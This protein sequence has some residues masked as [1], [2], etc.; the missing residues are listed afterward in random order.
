MAAVLNP[1]KS[2]KE[3]LIIMKNKDNIKIVLCRTWSPG[4][5]GSVLRAMKNF[6]FTNVVAVNQINENNDEI[7]TMA[8]GAKDHIKYLKKSSNLKEAIKD[9]NIVYAFTNRQRKFFKT[10]SPSQ[11]ASEIN[12]LAP[13]QKVALL[14][15]N[16]TNGLNSKEVDFADKIVVIPTSENY[17]S[18][19]LATAVMISLYEIH[20]SLL[21]DNKTKVAKKIV[22]LEEK[23]SLFEVISDV[24]C[25]K[26]IDKIHH[27]KQFE[28][29]VKFLLKKMALNNKETRFI[30]SLFKLIERKLDEKK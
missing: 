30:K 21:R 7:L 28:E 18:L 5:I 29:N 3:N 10:L 2:K 26:V 15:G 16:E 6:D 27:K 11:M 19:N 9:C 22:T 24:I 8:A 13:N 1:P 25:N 20:N 23:I 14:F 17:P 12:N 4:N